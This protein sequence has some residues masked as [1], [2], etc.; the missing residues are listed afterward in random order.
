MLC[1]PPRPPPPSPPPRAC[2]APSTSAGVAPSAGCAC[3]SHESARGGAV[4][5]AGRGLSESAAHEQGL[6]AVVAQRVVV[7]LE[8]LQRPAAGARDGRH[9]L[10]RTPVGYATPG[11]VERRERARRAQ[12]A[13]QCRHALLGEHVARDAQAGEPIGAHGAGERLR[14][15]GAELAPRQVERIQLRTRWRGLRRRAVCRWCDDGARE[16]GGAVVA[17]RIVGERERAQ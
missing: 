17:D 5:G 4:D 9:D 1:S 7:Q 16:R 15:G 10:Q 11:H 2:A 13:R 14:P 6:A 3:C 12:R 8:A